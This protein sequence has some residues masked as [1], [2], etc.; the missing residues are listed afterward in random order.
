MYR[1]ER[2]YENLNKGIFPGAGRFDIP[3]LRPEL[4]TAENWISFNYAKG[5]EEPSEHGVHFFVD[6]YQFNRIWAHP[7]NYLGMMARFDTVCTPDFSTYTDFPRIIQIYNHYRKH[8]LGAYWQAHG[9]KVI[10]TIS[11]STPDS[12]AWCF[13][14]EPIG[15]AV[16][17]SS[18]GTQANPESAD[19]FMAGYNEMLR[20]LQPAQI[21]FYGKVPAAAVQN[22]P[23]STAPQAMGGGSLLSVG[24]ISYTPLN[25]KDE[26][27][28]GKVWNGYDINT[29]LAINQYI[30]QDQTNTGYG[31][32]QN[33][34]HKLENGQALNANEQYMV[35]M[36]DAAMH[37]LGKNTT[38]I[39]AAHQDFLEALGVKNYQRMTDA[40][41]N[42]AVQGVEY[43]EKKFVSTAY[44]AKK[45]PFIGGSQSG[46]R[47]VFINISTPA[48]TNCIMGNLKQAE[49]IFSRDTKYRVKGA[50]FDGTFANPRVGGTLPRVIVDV[51]IYE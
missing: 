38:L 13:D 39:R 48:S 7:D 51:E 10:P 37:P 49:I 29:K 30:R 17:V 4:T 45:N 31:V 16:A 8:W 41:L 47:E 44:D 50:H 34:N 11:W 32:G 26:A 43:T 9:I 18:V 15:G 24:P 3:I 1:T 5:C 21:I 19:L 6:D 22:A 14:G 46:G 12:F 23:P 35:N 20:R 36:M 33:L 25:Q 40:Q 28:L 2:N 27:D 42:A